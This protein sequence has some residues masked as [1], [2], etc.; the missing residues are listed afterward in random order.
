MTFVG[1]ETKRM[2]VL[3]EEVRAVIKEF[4]TEN[5]VEGV[6]NEEFFTAIYNNTSAKTIQEFFI[7]GI[8][9]HRLMEEH[10]VREAMHDFWHNLPTAPINGGKK[11]D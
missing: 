3:V 11:A 6:S 7:V 10:L 9:A 5:P 2:D 8:N 4:L 1:I